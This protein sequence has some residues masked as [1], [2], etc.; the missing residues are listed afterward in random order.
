MKKVAGTVTI[1]L[2]DYHDLVYAEEK[3]NEGNERTKRASKELAVFLT[4]LA[5]RADVTPYIEEFNRQ[6]SSSFIKLDDGR[7]TI[8]FKNDSSQV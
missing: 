8:N 1:S 5:T 2:D 3:A 4:F 7:A 6:S